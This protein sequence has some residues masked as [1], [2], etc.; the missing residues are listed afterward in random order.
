MN[1]NFYAIH[2]KPVVTWIWLTRD[3]LHGSVEDASAIDSGKRPRV[4]PNL[5]CNNAMIPREESLRRNI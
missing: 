1:S 4:D 3:G 5:R 2:S